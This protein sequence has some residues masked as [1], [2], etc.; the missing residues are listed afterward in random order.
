MITLLL[1]STP[2]R[3]HNSQ[4]SPADIGWKMLERDTRAG[5]NAMQIHFKKAA[6]LLIGSS[7]M[8]YLITTGLLL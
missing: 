5:K 6:V 2:S 3:P 4:N 8:L 7:K 1:R